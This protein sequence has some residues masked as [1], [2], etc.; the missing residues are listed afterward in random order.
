MEYRKNINN[1]LNNIDIVLYDISYKKMMV[2]FIKEFDDF[3]NKFNYGNYTNIFELICDQFIRSVIIECSED[4]DS[5][6]EPAYRREFHYHYKIFD[7]YVI[8]YDSV[9]LH[10]D[11]CAD[12]F[13]ESEIIFNGKKLD[14]YEDDN[15][16]HHYQ[17]FNIQSVNH[18]I[19]DGYYY[20]KYSGTKQEILYDI[21]DELKNHFKN[22]KN[23][24]IKYINDN[25]SDEFVFK[26][27]NN[28]HIYMMQLYDK[29]VYDVITVSDKDPKPESLKCNIKI[30][31]VGTKQFIHKLPVQ[32]T[33]NNDE[34]IFD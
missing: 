12:S 31:K 15:K 25:N 18:G 7:N 14:V 6:P 11:S 22:I 32:K 33:L 19:S 20:K 23:K 30:E 24:Q 4:C 1:V 8:K 34:N 13:D 28:I 26:L 21:S 17:T 29:D 16:L 27:I 10:Y 5:D 2:R 3:K 9:H